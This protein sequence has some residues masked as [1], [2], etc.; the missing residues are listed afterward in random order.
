ML[1]GGFAFIWLAM[2]ALFLAVAIWPSRFAGLRVGHWALWGGVVLPLA[3]S[4]PLFA[5]AAL[6]THRLWPSDTPDVTIE[7]E[8]YQWSWR[9]TYPGVPGAVS[10]DVLYLPAGQEVA[11]RSTSSDVIHSV[12]IPRL[13]GKLDV[14]P[15]HVST[16]RLIADAPGVIEGQCAEFCGLGHTEMRFIVV[17]VTPQEYAATVAGLRAGTTP[18]SIDALD[19]ATLVAAQGAG[20]SAPRAPIPAERPSR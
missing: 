6:M 13:A 15:G 1:L 17:I 3:V 4:L 2:I 7:A 11:L 8:A 20:L 16:L 10:E 14:I 9:F 18:A 12:W 5:W 19:D